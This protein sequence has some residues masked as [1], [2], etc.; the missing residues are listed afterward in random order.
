[1]Q[2]HSTFSSVAQL[3]LTL[4]NPI[5]C[6][7]PGFPAQTPRTCSNSCPSG[8]WCH[9]TISSPAI[10]VSFSSCFQALPA[11]GSFQW[12]SSSHQVAK[13][14]EL[15]HQSSQ[16]IFRTDFLPDWLVWSL[17][18]PRDSQESSPMLQFKSINSSALSFLYGSTL[19]SVHE[20]W[21]NHS[22][23]YMCLCWQSNVSAF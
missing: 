13:V 18:S 3:Y 4:C 7:M 22:F 21:K 6:S 17:Q 1:M 10:L 15:Q 23:D 11:S 8:W 14:L 2:Y 12:V 20:S 16:R 9:P 19:T 5:D